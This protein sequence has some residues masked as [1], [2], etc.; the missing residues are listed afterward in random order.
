MLE[1]SV[2]KQL[3]SNDVSQDNIL[4]MDRLDVL[5]GR[6]SVKRTSTL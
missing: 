6:A 3:D 2:L 4:T 1:T 5:W